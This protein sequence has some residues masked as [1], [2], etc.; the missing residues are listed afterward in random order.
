LLLDTNAGYSATLADALD[1]FGVGISWR[2]R[3]L[4]LFDALAECDPIALVMSAEIPGSDPLDLIRSVR[5][6]RWSELPIFVIADEPDRSLELRAY[7]EGADRMLRR[8][9]CTGE[10]AAHIMGHARRRTRRRQNVGRDVADVAL[11]LCEEGNTPSPE[12]PSS[13]PTHAAFDD[14]PARLR[15]EEVPVDVLRPVDVAP[16]QDDLIATEG[17]VAPSPPPLAEAPFSEATVPDVILVD[18]DPSLLEMLRYA[19]TNR[20]YKTLSLSNGLD[21]LRTLSELETG[22]RRPVVLLD[23]DLPGLDGFR[24]LHEL[25]GCRP[26]AYQVILCT[27]HSSEATQVLGIQSGAVDYIVKPFRMPIVL[28]KVERLLGPAGVHSE[29]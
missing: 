3:L 18:D 4:G 5:G 28:A 24:I 1:R 13:E 25:S 8:D 9:G 15:L 7:V 20:G 16:L 29:A 12:N 11:A 23:V 26:G 17:G 19:M 27:V 10:L 22:D 21:A 2:G 14:D 6:S